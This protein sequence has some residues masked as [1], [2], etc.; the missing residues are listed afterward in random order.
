MSFMSI[1]STLDTRALDAIAAGLVPNTDTALQETAA[2]IETDV[3]INIQ[4]KHI[5]DTGRLMNSIHFYRMEQLVY[6]VEDGVEY[7]IY[8]ELGTRR[9]IVARPFFIPAVEKNTQVLYSKLSENMFK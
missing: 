7:G 9:G 1:S 3:K 2:A 6:A 5:I 4:T 8:Q